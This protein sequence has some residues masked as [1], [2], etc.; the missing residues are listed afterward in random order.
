MYGGTTSSNSSNIHSAHTYEA[1]IKALLQRAAQN[2]SSTGKAPPKRL[3]PQVDYLLQHSRHSI[4]QW[5]LV[6][7]GAWQDHHPLGWTGPAYGLLQLWQVDTVACDYTLWVV[8]ADGLPTGRTY[9]S[10]SG[11]RGPGALCAATTAAT[12]ARVRLWLHMAY[13]KPERAHVDCAL[14]E[15]GLQVVCAV[16]RRK[17]QQQYT[18][19]KGM[20]QCITALSG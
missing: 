15:Q 14:N 3:P 19:I 5:L 12:K 2:S 16:T 20:I 8:D 10:A 4:D 17:P 7:C 6:Q 13:S 9:N 1:C 18:S 11:A